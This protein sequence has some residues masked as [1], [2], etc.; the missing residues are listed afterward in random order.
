[1]NHTSGPWIQGATDEHWKR[2]VRTAT[3]E[4]VAWCGSF[5]VEQAHAN[6]RFIANAPAMLAALNALVDG[7]ATLTMSADAWRNAESVIAKAEGK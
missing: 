4:S 6:A 2:S 7:H 3:G 1:M 5:P